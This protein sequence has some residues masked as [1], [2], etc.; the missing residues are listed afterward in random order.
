MVARKLAERGHTCRIVEVNRLSGDGH[1][2]W[3]V[4][5]EPGTVLDA[6][7]R[8][9]VVRELGL[10]WCRRMRVPPV[11]PDHVRDPEA[12]EL[13]DRNCRAALEGLFMTEFRGRW[14]SDP[15][16]T[17]AAETKPVQLR[18]ANAAGLRVPRTLVSQD[19]D[20]VRRFC[21]QLGFRVVVKALAASRA[22]P[23][24]TGRVT[25]EILSDDAIRLT[26]A[27]YQELVPGTRH[28]RVCLFGEQAHAALLESERLDWRFPHDVEASAC[29][30]D[31]ATLAKLRQLL[32]DLGL[33]MGMF[34]LKPAEDGEP[35]WLEL[36]PQGQFLFLE[37]LCGMPLG[38]VCADFLL[39]QAVD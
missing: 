32:K 2:S 16:A 24:M 11:V 29:E 28:L 14:V 13:I 20:R 19:P 38:D 34:D 12:R 7:G 39:A 9:I 26:P 31:Q 23:T 33:R 17:Q 21:E 25:S 10:V 22:V 8:P 4:D 5:G 18:A 27:I 3:Q 35:V 1:L 36:N 15:R 6:E 30:L 37:G